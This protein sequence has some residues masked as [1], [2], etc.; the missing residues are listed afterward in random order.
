M[1]LSNYRRTSYLTIRNCVCHSVVQV[2][3]G[4]EA[5]EDQWDALLQA[6]GTQFSTGTAAIGRDC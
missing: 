3:D 5:G 2:L 1:T 6:A 4:D